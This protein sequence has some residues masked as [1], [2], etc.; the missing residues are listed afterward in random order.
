MESQHNTLRDIRWINFFTNADSRGALTAIE[1]HK[2]VPMEIKRIFYMR[3]MSSMRGGHANTDTDQVIIPIA[4][5]FKMKLFDEKDSKTFDLN[6]A[7]KGLYI[8][9]MI[10]LDIFD[11]SADAVCLVLANTTYNADNYYRDLNE[12]RKSFEKRK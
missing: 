6:D 2:D 1:S 4:G 12:Y 9:R 5:S 7:T 10:F 8:P 3:N 11:F